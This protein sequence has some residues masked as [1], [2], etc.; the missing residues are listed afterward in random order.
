MAI[1]RAA[2]H[3]CVELTAVA[4]HSAVVRHLPSFPF[5]YRAGLA[6]TFHYIFTADSS[7][8]RTL[9]IALLNT[10]SETV[11]VL[12]KTALLLGLVFWCVRLRAVY[13]YL[14]VI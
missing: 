8:L 7:D 1:A 11:P 6:L 4:G 9:P 14:A 2:V 12:A 3:V 13:L 10:R 5:A